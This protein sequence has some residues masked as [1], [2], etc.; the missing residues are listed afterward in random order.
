MHRIRGGFTLIELLVVIAII[1]ILAAMLFPV[2]A[3]ARERARQSSCVNNQRQIV[4]TI[5]MYAQDND[6]M[7]P[8][9]ATVWQKL[10]LPPMTLICLTKG[11]K[12]PNAY[13]YNSALDGVA[14]GTFNDPGSVL[15]T[16]DGVHAATSSPLTYD[17]IAYNATDYDL[18][19]T[20]RMVASFLDGHVDSITSAGTTD[21]LLMLT[22]APGYCMA[23][24]V[25]GGYNS[26]QSWT[27]PGG[28]TF[29]GP[30]T[31]NL[32]QIQPVGM[33]GATGLYFNN[34]GMSK[35]QVLQA[36]ADE[37]CTLGAVFASNWA[38]T[39]TNSEPCMIADYYS[40]YDGVG[41]HWGAYGTSPNHAGH[42][43]ARAYIGVSPYTID[44]FSSNTYNDG[45]THVAIVTFDPHVGITLYVDGKQDGFT[46]R[47]TGFFTPYYSGESVR[48]GTSTNG[49]DQYI[50]FLGAVFYYNY[51]F[52]QQDINTLTTQMRTQF[53]F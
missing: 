6:D 2:F 33:N 10:A 28:S 4:M 42:L 14:Q 5:H 34:N 46:A 9:A 7:L 3:K 20:G 50:G 30:T 43:R 17:N 16:A 13:V 51:V 25:Y 37:S 8:P 27:M 32:I 38:A 35:S 48:I 26:L 45:N 23:G 47:T 53:N 49:P 19:H 41:L 11:M 44:C 1:A 40:N 12:Y 29:S 15:V 22:T 18:R 36:N 24:S 39:A 52:K 21:A 31:G